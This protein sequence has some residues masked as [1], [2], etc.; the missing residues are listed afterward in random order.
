MIILGITGS[1]GMGKSTASQMLEKLGVPIHDSDSGIHDLLSAKSEAW[2]DLTQIFP[3]YLYPQIYKWS[4]KGRT[5]INR[6]AMG[7]LVFTNPILRKKLESILH[8]WVRKY[9]DR[10]ISKHRQN[11]TPII[12]LDIPLLFETG[13][14][15]RMDYVVNISAPAYIQKRRVMARPNMTHQKFE[16]IVAAQMSDGEKCARAD[17]VVHSGLGRAQMMRKLKIILSII[18]TDHKQAA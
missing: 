18:R 9:Q 6:K 2:K 13:A 5:A 3:A 7:R 4:L 15:D 11:G 16:N 12:G 17:F 1:I 14:Q 8:P 10:F